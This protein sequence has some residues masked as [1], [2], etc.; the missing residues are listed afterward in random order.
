MNLADI[1]TRNNPIGANG[2][3]KLGC[4]GAPAA[5]MNAVADVTGTRAVDMPATLERPGRAVRAK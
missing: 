5:L 4:V 1:P 3:G 2:A